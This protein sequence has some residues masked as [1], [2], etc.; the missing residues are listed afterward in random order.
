MH[1]FELLTTRPRKGTPEQER[2]FGFK[3]FED[4]RQVNKVMTGKTSL[5][6]E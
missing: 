3:K 6:K 4:I 5:N 1:L 2:G